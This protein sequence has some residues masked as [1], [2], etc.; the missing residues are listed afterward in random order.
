MKD[1]LG[2]VKEHIRILWLTSLTTDILN[3]ILDSIRVLA[4]ITLSLLSLLATRL[5]VFLLWIAVGILPCVL[6]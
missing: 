6:F 3:N 5:I 1:R 4:I 2:S